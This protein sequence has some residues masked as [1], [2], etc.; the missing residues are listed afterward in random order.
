MGETERLAFEPVDYTTLS[1][2]CQTLF[3]VFGCSIFA[4]RDERRTRKSKKTV[5]GI[6]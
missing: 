6:I 5:E 1:A 3:T 4:L 2:A